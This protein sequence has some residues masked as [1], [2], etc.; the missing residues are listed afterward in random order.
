MLWALMYFIFT[1]TVKVLRRI[2][3]LIRKTSLS[4]E[5]TS[6]VYQSKEQY[7]KSEQN[8]HWTEEKGYIFWLNFFYIDEFLQLKIHNRIQLTFSVR[9]YTSSGAI[10]VNNWRTFDPIKLICSSIPLPV[11]MMIFVYCSNSQANLRVLDFLSCESIIKTA[12]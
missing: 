8:N 9:E 11:T 3:G 5:L 10:G 4:K 12:I 6:L 1:P 7:I 2:N